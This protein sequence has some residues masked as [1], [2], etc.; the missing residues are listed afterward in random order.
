MNTITL[1]EPSRFP[2]G[3]AVNPSGTRVYVTNTCD[4]GAIGISTCA[5]G[6]TGS[7]SVIDTAS[8]TVI[9]TITVGSEPAGIVVTQ[10]ESRV[11]VANACSG[12][13]TRGEGDPA[14][15]GSVSVIDVVSGSATENTVIATI[16]LAADYA[17]GIAV[18][19][20]GSLVY[21]SS[22]V[23]PTGTYGTV[24][25]IDTATNSLLGT[26]PV[27]AA[28]TGLV[29]NP[30]SARLYVAS[31]GAMFIG[32]AGAQVAVSEIEAGVEP[33]RAAIRPLVLRPSEKVLKNHFNARLF[34]RILGYGSSAP[35]DQRRQEGSAG[36]AS[37]AE[38]W[39]A[40]GLC[41]PAGVGTPA[42]G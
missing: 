38:K 27:P 30:V 40:A 32:R 33:T 6:D 19:Q 29:L 26:I 20:S 28:A 24:S 25:V 5:L 12:D 36:I 3:V 17:T 35:E 1:P 2:A 9:K 4:G 7:V 16:A 37:P 22:L 39:S 15:L 14:S 18:N 42:A 34:W 41:D 10:N 31:V 21:V 11:Y 23:D 13:C 8:N